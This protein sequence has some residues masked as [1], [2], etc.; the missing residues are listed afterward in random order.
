MNSKVLN[1]VKNVAMSVAVIVGLLIFI[2][3]LYGILMLG[4]INHVY[5][6]LDQLKLI[7]LGLTTTYISNFIKYRVKIK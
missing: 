2:K 1:L 7:G 6:L 4:R 3:G 5:R